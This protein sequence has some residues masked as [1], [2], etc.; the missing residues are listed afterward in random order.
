MKLG[1]AQCRCPYGSNFHD[2]QVVFGRSK[3]SVEC[4]RSLISRTCLV[5]FT[6]SRIGNAG[7][8]L[9]ATEF[10]LFTGSRD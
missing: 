3:E 6:D 8:L 7:V 9:G 4:H 2:H 10:R 5:E 1:L